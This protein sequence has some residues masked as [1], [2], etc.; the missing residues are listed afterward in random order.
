VYFYNIAVTYHLP[1]SIE[2]RRAVIDA[3][4]RINFKVAS[5]LRTERLGKRK[6]APFLAVKWSPVGKAIAS[7]KRKSLRQGYGTF[8]AKTVL[9]VFNDYSGR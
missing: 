7:A 4:K 8:C 3:A 6:S 1:H 9:L 2:D 5:R